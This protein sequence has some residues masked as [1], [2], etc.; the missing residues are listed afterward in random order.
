MEVNDRWNVNRVTQPMLDASVGNN[1]PP[2]NQIMGDEQLMISADGD[3][4]NC[5]SIAASSYIG[6]R[7]CKKYINC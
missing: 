3:R 4:Y 5:T 1:S 2:T 6:L 7:N